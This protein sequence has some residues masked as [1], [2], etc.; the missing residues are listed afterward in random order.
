MTIGRVS[1]KLPIVQGGMGVGV[2]TSP[3]AGAVSAEGALGTLSSACID[4]VVSKRLGRKVNTREAMKIEVLEAK[5]GRDIPVAVNIMVALASSYEDAVLGSLDGGAEVIISGAGLPLNLPAIVAR[6]PRGQE[7]ELVPIVSSGRAAELICKRWS[8][9]GRAPSAMIVEGPLAGGHLGWKTIA[10]IEDPANSL[11]NILREVLA[12]SAA[13]G[14]FPVIA[15]GGIYTHEDIWKYLDMGA[16]GVQLGTRF[17]ATVESGASEEFKKAVVECGQ[18]S[19][20]VA[21]KPGSP[22]Q[23]PFRVLKDCG[24][25][26]E[27]L[28]VLREANCDKGYLLRSGV[29]L[30][31]DDPAGY[32][33]IC[34]G[35]LSAADVNADVEKPLFTV[36]T[37]AYRIDRIITVSELLKELATGNA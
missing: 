12:V 10:E 8:K 14:N 22:C 20:V 25:Y 31:N 29:C 15:A 26:K 28:A 11:E 2:S 37:N 34:N 13:T 19:I 9:S 33:C 21:V 5:K 4:A 6:H 16:D 1:L 7:V 23:M 27:S 36:G 3:L 32:F 35:L 17:L 30:G 18:D 24:M